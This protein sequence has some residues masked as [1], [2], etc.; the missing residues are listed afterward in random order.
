MQNNIT[1]SRFAAAVSD[2]CADG[3]I[4]NVEAYTDYSMIDTD[5]YAVGAEGGLVYIHVD[6]E[7]APGKKMTGCEIAEFEQGIGEHAVQRQL[8]ELADDQAHYVAGRARA[9]RDGT[10]ASPEVTSRID[11]DLRLLARRLHTIQDADGTAEQITAEIRVLD[12]TTV[13]LA[14][15]PHG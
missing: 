3:L 10:A 14:S 13:V 4:T 11:D 6:I 8:S 9:E 12:P 1:K 5:I 2:H 15:D 7:Y